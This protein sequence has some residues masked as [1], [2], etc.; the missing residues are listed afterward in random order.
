M[1]I[2]YNLKSEL[3][4]LLSE[5][6]PEFARREGGHDVPDEGANWIRTFYAIYNLYIR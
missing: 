6:V 1:R 3:M 4:D 5:A 2:F